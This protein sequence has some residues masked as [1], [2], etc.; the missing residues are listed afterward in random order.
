MS[1]E[2]KYF[3]GNTL[4]QAILQAARYFNLEPEELAY[5]PVERRHGFLKV[6]RRAVVEV[7][8]DNPK[9]PEEASAPSPA[10]APATPPAPEVRPQP[11]EQPDTAGPSPPAM[12]TL[13]E[14][15]AR[16]SER[17]PLAEGELAEAAQEAIRRLAKLGRISIEADVHRSEEGLEVELSGDDEDLLLEDRGRLLLS[18]QHLLPR[19]IR[20]LTGEGI[21][22]RVDCDNFH[23]IRAEQLRV[24]AQKVAAEVRDRGRPRSLEPMSPDERRIVHVTLTDDPA[25]ETESRGNGL[26]KRVMIKPKRRSRGFDPYSP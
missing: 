1:Q 13:P 5:R 2:K 24:L 17:F 7:E 4:E 16:A 3:S 11:V 14:E 20:G 22:C 10:G 23:E 19:L 9:K 25:V 21:A 6:R 18:A 12:T 15:P 26:F 8:L